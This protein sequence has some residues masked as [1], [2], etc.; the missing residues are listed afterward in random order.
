MVCYQSKITKA[1][2]GISF[3]SIIV[4][5]FSF[6]LTVPAFAEQITGTG[7]VPE[8]E[9]YQDDSGEWKVKYLNTDS[10]L[11]ADSAPAVNSD[12]VEVELYQDQAGEWKVKYLNAD[13]EA[14]E[15]VKK[16]IT[17]PVKA[18]KTA[19]SKSVKT[20]ANVQTPSRD[21]AQDSSREDSED[22]QIGLRPIVIDEF[23]PKPNNEYIPE[24][25]DE[26]TTLKSIEEINKPS[27]D[28]HR[29]RSDRN[30]NYRIELG[31]QLSHYNFEQE[32]KFNNF[33]LQTG[34]TN[35]GMLYGLHAGYEWLPNASQDGVDKDHNG[36]IRYKLTLDYAIGSTTYSDINE[37][38]EEDFIQHNVESRAVAGYDINLNE[39]NRVTPFFG[40][41]YRY[42][43]D[44]SGSIVDFPSSGISFPAQNATFSTSGF[45][46]RQAYDVH[47]HYL[48]L[49]VGIMT[50]SNI[51]DTLSIGFSMELD[52]LIWGMVKNNFS[53]IG[54]LYFED[55]GSRTIKPSSMTNTLKGGFGFRGSTR[56][57]KKQNK[58][59]LYAEPFIRYWHVNQSERKQVRLK[60][61]D[62]TDLLLYTD[63]ALT[64]PQYWSEPTNSTT[65][66]GVE[67]GVSF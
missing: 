66:Y 41:G 10:S 5:S 58:F 44:P 37:L 13:N 2:M 35:E 3:A 26:K 40:V 57:T 12:N 31:I 18:M 61:S 16:K 62:G 64:I 43:F 11:S 53:E 17:K 39:R 19:E 55:G 54:D 52:A 25:S 6:V 63:N 22:R 24:P 60:I 14:V 42:Q 29:E 47:T 50:N 59:D 7:D 48:Y 21:N 23:E 36:V 34:K 38:P 4:L 8:V 27:D 1:F 65:E 20:E 51:T 67:F 15:T 45:N 56:I 9:L 32:P 49:P 30:P 33:N 28:Q 46:A